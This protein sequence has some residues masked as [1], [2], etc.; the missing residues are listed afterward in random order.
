[1]YV[2]MYVYIYI[3]IYAYLYA[4]TYMYSDIYRVH[5][6]SLVRLA[7]LFHTITMTNTHIHTLRE[8]KASFPRT[9]R[10]T[11]LSAISCAGS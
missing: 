4:C 3:Y 11:L 6:F 5:S 2:C 7:F 8:E 9:G 1:M 10:L